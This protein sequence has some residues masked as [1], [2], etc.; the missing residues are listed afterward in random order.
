[1]W[2]A[3]TI[4]TLER[5]KI[6]LWKSI[7]NRSAQCK[8][9]VVY[10]WMDLVANLQHDKIPETMYLD[11]KRLAFLHSVF[12]KNVQS[13]IIMAELDKLHHL[14]A[15]VR[16]TVQQQVRQLMQSADK[17]RK[18]T[19]MET[20]V[21]L[22]YV[23]TKVQDFCKDLLVQ[24]SYFFDTKHPTYVAARLRMWG[25]WWYTLVKLL[26][27]GTGPSFWPK[28]DEGVLE[29][30]SFLLAIQADNIAECS[31]VQSPPPQETFANL[32]NL[33][34]MICCNFSIHGEKYMQI[35]R[36]GPIREEDE[37]VRIGARF[38][39][40]GELLIGGELFHTHTQ[41]DTLFD[42]EQDP[43]TPLKP[44]TCCQVSST[45]T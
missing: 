6:H 25:M 22:V 37:M 17:N 8:V 33:K 24:G 43:S 16:S 21:N 14:N 9:I 35:M 39:L 41:F 32:Q 11:D 30:R 2:V 19:I 40:E 44:P 23:H 5:R 4:A 26:L 42:D 1:M 12:H 10:G 3:R 31:L 27:H 45:S 38:C 29:R 28:G 13:S 15:Q 36:E 34:K 7:K 18:D 20:V